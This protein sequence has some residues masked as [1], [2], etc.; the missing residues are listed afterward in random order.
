MLLSNEFLRILERFVYLLFVRFELIF[1]QKELILLPLDLLMKVLFGDRHF[2]EGFS[3][4]ADKFF[5][6]LEC[7]PVKYALALLYFRS[8]LRCWTFLIILII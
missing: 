1:D 2:I 4:L 5:D 3:V 6:I 8:C 7:V